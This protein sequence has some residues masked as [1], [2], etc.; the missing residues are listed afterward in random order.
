MS[1]AKLLA[2]QNY[3]IISIPIARAV[4]LEAAFLLHHLLSHY[5]FFAKNNQLTPNGGQLYFYATVD[6]IE[7]KT[8]LTRERQTTAIKNLVGA[9]LLEQKN[10][11][12]PCR[13][14]FAIPEKFDERINQLAGNTPTSSRETHKLDNVQNANQHAEKP[15]AIYN[16]KYNS[17]DNNTSISNEI[18]ES[19][20]AATHAPEK[21][22]R[23]KE[24]K[25]K[26]K[27]ALVDEPQEEKEKN[28]GKKE[29]DAAGEGEDYLALG[30][31]PAYYPSEQL[32]LNSVSPEVWGAFIKAL[33]VR[34]KKKRLPRSIFEKWARDI[35]TIAL[36]KQY[37]DAVIIAHLSDYS[38]SK[39][40]SPF[41]T[42]FADALDRKQKDISKFSKTNTSDA[43]N[44][45]NTAANNS[46]KPTPKISA[47]DI[48]RNVQ[49]TN[50]LD[51]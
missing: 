44:S 47:E 16:S 29:K 22:I 43:N 3:A 9:G 5:D 33:N 11:G 23:Q 14:H 42:G 35:F 19:G 24:N 39:W 40:Q 18:D 48:M 12:I 45:R 38:A 6:D 49:Q 36:S 26:P 30:Q 7:D 15:P 10:F 2:S 20:E 13:R 27:T 46:P 51:F 21:K 17:I 41:F 25:A 1:I 31:L 34:Y 4:G 37:S 32:S 28:C 8:A 50:Q